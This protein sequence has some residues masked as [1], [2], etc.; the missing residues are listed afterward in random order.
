MLNMSGGVDDDANHI[1][2]KAVRVKW[3]G[4]TILM[5][6]KMM[7]RMIMIHQVLSSAGKMDG[8]DDNDDGEGDDDNDND[9]D[10]DILHRC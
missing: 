7:M 8:V 5:M 1:R 9:D 6:V 2:F 3:M 4:L 10:I